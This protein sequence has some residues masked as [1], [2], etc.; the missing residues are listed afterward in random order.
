MPQTQ[1]DYSL[2]NERRRLLV[3][4]TM[5]VIS[6]HGFSNLT[7]AKVAGVAGLTAGSVNFHFESKEALLLATLQRVADDFGA[8]LKQALAADRDERAGRLHFECEKERKEEKNTT[9]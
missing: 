8:T 1:I 7:L 5:S 4:A 9:Q 2:P 6:E 3:E